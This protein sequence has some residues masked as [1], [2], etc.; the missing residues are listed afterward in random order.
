MVGCFPMDRDKLSRFLLQI[1]IGSKNTRPRMRFA[2]SW[3]SIP[4]FPDEREKFWLKFKIT[5]SVGMRQVTQPPF[6]AGPSDCL[7]TFLKS[8]GIEYLSFSPDKYPN[9]HFTK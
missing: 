7:I 5:F 2:S 6:I 3:H 1:A 4:V 8:P 9:T